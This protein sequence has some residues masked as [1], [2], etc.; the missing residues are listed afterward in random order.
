MRR[1][2]HA[3]EPPESQGRSHRR[4][5]ARE[6]PRAPR[7]G[8]DEPEPWGQGYYGSG[9]SYGYGGGFE[10]RDEQ[11]RQRRRDDAEHGY[12]QDAGYWQSG[13]YRDQ[14]AAEPYERYGTFTGYE[15]GEFARRSAGPAEAPQSP[16]RRGRYY[17]MSPQGYTRSDERIREDICD[18]LMHGHVDPRSIHVR[19][20]RGEVTLEGQVETRRDK[21]LVEDLVES[22]LGVR[23]VDN[24]L[25]VPRPGMEKSGGER[26]EGD[27]GR[28][29]KRPHN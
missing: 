27:G 12:A 16:T 9:G 29:G 21:Y 13:G 28:T 25:R 17:G 3:A 26:G 6:D 11:H 5:E 4:G 2:R 10:D 23:D 20:E 19:V 24:R 8:R 1:R 22:V 18:Q 7:G 14:R 15:E